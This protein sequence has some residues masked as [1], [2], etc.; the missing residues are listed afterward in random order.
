ML[1]VASPAGTA[2]R[3]SLRGYSV[4]G[5]TGTAQK[6]VN[7][8]YSDSLFRATFCGIVPASS[9][10]LVILV[11][12]DFDSREKFHQGGNS[13]GPVFRDITMSTLRY[14]MIPP[15]RPEE[16]DDGEDE[17]ELDRMIDERA[18]EHSASAT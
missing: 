13:A 4:A 17:D 16:L 3:A 5:K 7:G 12:L 14:L 8:H 1:G 10:R 11:T 9:P 2:R 15:D 18:M 6:V